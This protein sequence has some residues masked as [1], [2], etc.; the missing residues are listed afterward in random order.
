MKVSNA[1]SRGERGTARSHTA[2]S[3]TKARH[4]RAT[5]VELASDAALRAVSC[6][7]RLCLDLHPYPVQYVVV[8]T[9]P[10]FNNIR[11]GTTKYGNS[12]YAKEPP[13]TE[14]IYAKKL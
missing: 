5:H 4:E 12:I 14:I 2:D 9:L 13:D 1:A 11:K 7:I 10:F 8:P 6:C 3:G